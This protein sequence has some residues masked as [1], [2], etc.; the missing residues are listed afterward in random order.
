M[1]YLVLSIGA[2]INDQCLTLVTYHW[3]PRLNCIWM[4]KVYYILGLKFSALFL[5]TG[6]ILW[7]RLDPYEKMEHGSGD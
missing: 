5:P 7:Q 2:N 4:K 1:S 3:S 6:N